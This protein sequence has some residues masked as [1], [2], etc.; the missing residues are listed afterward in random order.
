MHSDYSRKPLLHTSFPLRFKNG[1]R[2]ETLGFWCTRCSRIADKSEVYGNLGMIVPGTVDVRAIYPCQCGHTS[3]YRI[4]LKD[5][6]S[7]IY[8]QNER[9]RSL[10]KT[11]LPMRT[12][13]MFWV[14]DTLQA[15]H[16]KWLYFRIERKLTKLMK[17]GSTL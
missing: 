9:W 10:K 13:I 4:R 8:L 14:T 15:W 5:D 3:A 16:I 12:R 1:Y 7:C 6:G 11:G 17:R 2:I